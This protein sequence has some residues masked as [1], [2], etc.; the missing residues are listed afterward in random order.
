MDLT[1]T[2]RAMA[3]TAECT[4]ANGGYRNRTPAPRN[5]PFYNT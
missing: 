2:Y 4:G 3:L 1:G 5:N